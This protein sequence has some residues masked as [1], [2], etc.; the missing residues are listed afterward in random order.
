M[1]KNEELEYLMNPAL[2]DKYL[3]LSSKERNL[4]FLEEKKFYRKRI[5][6]MAKDCSKFCIVKGATV[7]PPALSK[8]FD[9]FSK[10]CIEHFKLIDEAEIYQNEYKD[11]EPNEDNHY[12]IDNSEEKV[13]FIDLDTSLLSSSQNN[14][15]KIVS[16]DDFVTKKQNKPKKPL[17]LPKQK[18][19]NVK[20]E[21]YR[22]KGLKKNKSK[23]IIGNANKNE[24]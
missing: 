5:Q 21:K 22:T 11:I 14:N 18:I 3:Q 20:D 9:Y 24:K 23:D 10:I 16:M 1:D 8:A 12:L 2:Y 15:K 17:H 19:A 6:Q 7:P 4:A 13:D